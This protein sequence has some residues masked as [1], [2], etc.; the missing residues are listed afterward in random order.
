MHPR[1]PVGHRPALADRLV[2]RGG[3]DMDA[4]LCFTCGTKMRPGGQLLRARGVRVYQ[5]L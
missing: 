3:K 2:Y 4:P 5:L 1:P